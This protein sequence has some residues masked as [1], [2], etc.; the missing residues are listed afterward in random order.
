GGGRH[1]S[2]EVPPPL[3][4]VDGELRRASNARTYPIL[5]PATGA[6]IGSA[7]DAGAADVDA[8]IAA[9]CRAFDTTDWSREHRFRVHC[10]RQLHRALV[11][12]GPRMR[13]LTTAEAGA[14]AFLTAGPQYDVPVQALSW[15][16]E[17]AD[18]Y[19]WSCDL[20]TAEPMGIPTRRAVHREATGVVA[21]ITPWN[22]PNQINLAKIGPALAA[23]NAVV[24]KPAPDT[25]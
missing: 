9:A 10:L 15:T 5:D 11:E 17:L 2:T 13:E 21:A 8:A 3:L 23:G 18:G 1:V 22:F 20:G 25:P 7:P 14:P 4:C 24:L 6:E 19:Q 12:H 16:T